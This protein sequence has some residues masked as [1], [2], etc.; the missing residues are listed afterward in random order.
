MFP[1]AQRARCA[2]CLA[3]VALAV[4]AAPERAAADMARVGVLCGA[5]DRYRRV[6]ESLAQPLRAAGHECRLVEL[7]AGDEAAEERAMQQLA[8]FRPTVIMAGGT[9]A[10]IRALAAV[11]DVPVI[12]FMVPNARDAPFLDQRSPHRRRV[13]GVSSD[14]DP[15]EQVRWIMQTHG[16]VRS[17]AVLCGSRTE[18]TVAALK[19]AGAK[20]GLR[21]HAVRAKRDAFPKAIEALANT[22]CDGV[23]MIP[24]SD[25]YDPDTVK[26]LLLW[27]V[28]HKKPIWTFTPNVVKA[29]AFAGIQ[30]SLDSVA[31]K[32]AE[33]AQQV[34]ARKHPEQIS[35]QYADHVNC[36]VNTHVAEMIGVSLDK[37]ALGP[38]VAYTGD[39]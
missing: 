18:R 12:F 39:R 6:A 11:P 37:R 14:V 7:P 27:G 32:A 2:A 16:S 38:N 22:D 34:I 8:D 4:W 10:T 13:T 29:G 24:D 19:D 26:R 3:A 17:V 36:S 31:A 9:M 20:R 23:L 5:A 21:I 28:R 15:T 30:A 25:V 33:I 1:N 35:L